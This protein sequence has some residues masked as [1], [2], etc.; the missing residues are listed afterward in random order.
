MIFAVF[1]NIL[2]EMKT[3]TKVY[4][5]AVQLQNHEEEHINNS[6]HFDMKIVYKE[7]EHTYIHLGGTCVSFC[8]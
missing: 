5:I 8:M 7:M 1:D 4:K 3:V 6:V 2:I